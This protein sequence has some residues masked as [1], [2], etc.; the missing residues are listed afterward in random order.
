MDAIVRNVLVGSVIA[1]SL[2]AIVMCLLVLRYS[3]APP[4]DEPARARHRR[5]F[6]T[7][8]GHAFAGACFAAT[9]ALTM[10]ALALDPGARGERG[11]GPDLQGLATRVGAIETMV[12][13]TA[14]AVTRSLGRV[15]HPESRRASSWTP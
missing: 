3:F 11:Q 14:T 10:V 6:V 8:L 1:S 12:R 15:D 5:I 13:E 2:G 9:A 7:R 4:S